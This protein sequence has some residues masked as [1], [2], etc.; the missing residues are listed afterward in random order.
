MSNHA[1]MTLV[2]FSTLLEY[3]QYV[4]LKAE[5]HRSSVS[6][7]ELLRRAIDQTYAPQRRPQLAGLEFNFGIWRRADAAI[8]G[9]LRERLRR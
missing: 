4:M 5:S 9:R 7:S 8:L 6:V 2:K 3:E 1:E